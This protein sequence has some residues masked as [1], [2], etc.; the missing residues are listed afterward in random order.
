MNH[1]PYRGKIELNRKKSPNQ[2]LIRSYRKEA[3]DFRSE[4]F[5]VS[6]KNLK[7]YESER[8]IILVDGIIYEYNNESFSENHYTKLLESFAK[9]EESTLQKINGEFTLILLDRV[10][11]TTWFAV[12]ESGIAAFFYMKEGQNFHFSNSTASLIHARCI[13]KEVNFQRVYDILTGNN[14]G[15][16]E[17]C[18]EGIERL[19]P[20]CYVKIADESVNVSEYSKIFLSKRVR[21]DLPNIYDSFRSVF[22]HA[23][24]IRLF[25]DRVGIAL[26]S[27]K[28][29]TAVAAFADPVCSGRGQELFGYCY[30]PTYLPEDLLSDNRY[31]ETILLQQFY[32]DYPRII[33]R[34]VE[35]PLGSIISSLRN[36]SLI[37]GEPVFGASNQFWIQKMQQMLIEDQCEIMMT[38]QGGNFTISWPPSELIKSRKRTIKKLYQNVKSKN[39]HDVQSIMPYF[40]SDF[41]NAIQREK[42]ANILVNTP[43]N[44]LQSNFIKRSISYSGYLQKQ[45]SLF[46]G[47]HITDPTLDKEVIRFCLSTPFNVYH[48]KSG[49]RNLVNQGLKKHL[50]KSVRENQIR[51][52]QGADIRFRL[53]QEKESIIK[54][55]IFLN[56]NKLVTFVFNIED[57]QNDLK[58]TD[59]RHLKIREC[60]HLLRVIQMGQFLADYIN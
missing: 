35:V 1:F 60:H 40:S 13:S 17:T 9:D 31:N 36:A 24:S 48:N 19:N 14:L 12:S 49:S 55:L 6:N 16:S 7:K 32:N 45:A 33:S 4:N 44:S 51:S 2:G 34:E 43:I 54:S 23:V 53:H 5:W 58:N 29:S 15:S 3:E 41:I 47:I 20:G 57:L 50:P 27:G 11:H 18:F 59:F 25:A 21:K 42:S 10:Y 39:W 8:Y 56:K 37:Y 52:M 46:Y 28:D 38:G 22:R 30:K 26:S